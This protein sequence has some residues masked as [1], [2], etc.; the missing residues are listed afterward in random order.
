MLIV[1][2]VKIFNVVLKGAFVVNVGAI[3]QVWSNDKYRAIEHRAM[4]N[5]NK[6]RLS[7]P[8]FFYPDIKTNVAPVPEL[9]DQDHQPPRY[10]PYNWEKKNTPEMA[11][12]ASLLYLTLDPDQ[13]IWEIRLLR[14]ER[15]I[16]RHCTSR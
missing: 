4:V 12:Y 3:F 16:T 11:F 2:N 14:E 8:V 15:I 9:L 10:Q 6:E 13:R 7:I 5:E 1:V